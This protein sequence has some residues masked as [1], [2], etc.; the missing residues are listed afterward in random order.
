MAE[1][2]S[3]P[4]GR[5]RMAC[6][7]IGSGP[8][9]VLIHGM[10]G[11]SASW[12]PVLDRLAAHF[13]VVAVDLPGHGG[14]ANPGG[15]YSLGAHASCVRDLMIALGIERATIVGHSFGGGV[16]MQTAYQFPERCERLIL[17]N[18]G[19]LGPEVAGF[20]RA[21]SLP[22]SELVLSVGCSDR[23]VRAGSAVARA[24]QK[25]GLRPTPST[26]AVVQHYASLTSPGARTTLLRT[27]R[28]VIDVG[29]QRVSAIDRLE[30]ASLIP[31]LIV[32]GERDRIIPVRH[33]RDAH[34][35]IPGSALR[36]IDGA[37]HFPHHDDP[38]GV[39][40]AL[41]EFVSST[42]PAVLTED[43]IRQLLLAS[44]GPSRP[45]PPAG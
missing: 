3:V 44:S 8:P 36:I 18:S 4:I 7:T 41:V 43:R 30:L 42:E 10:A 16:A 2:R 29:G 24:F 34:A 26:A 21:L 20:M 39:A 28:G 45:A 9:M 31:T 15:D 12:E 37:G 35:A 14:S 32:W 25:I 40:G 19:G 22:G 1:L 6:R 5:R 27:L 33:A 11:S 38:A 23:I 17:V 13:S